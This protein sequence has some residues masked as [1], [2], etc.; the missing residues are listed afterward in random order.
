MIEQ[1]G[2]FGKCQVVF[3]DELRA[4]QRMRQALLAARPGGKGH[5]GKGRINRSYYAFSPL[6]LHLDIH[7]VLEHGLH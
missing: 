3:I 1:A 4:G 6:A 7:A 5:F 2:C